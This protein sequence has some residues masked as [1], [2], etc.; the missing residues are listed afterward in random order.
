MSNSLSIVNA[1]VVVRLALTIWTAK[2]KLNRSDLPDTDNLPPEELASLGSKRLF[3][4]AKLRPF[5]AIKSRAVSF[6]DKQGVKFLGGW[7]I[8][9]KNVS[10]VSKELAN[11]HTEF[12]TAV[13]SFVADYTAGVQDWLA[14]YPQ[15]SNVL[16]NAMPS[17]TEIPRRFNFTWQMYKVEPV[18]THHTASD[19][20]DM[21]DSIRGVSDKALTEVQSMM[22]KVYSE[23]FAGK[24]EHINRK[25]LRTAENV[26][27]KLDKMSFTHPALSMIYS[28]LKDTIDIMRQPHV[29]DANQR[30]FHR[31][32]HR[33]CHTD[34]LKAILEHYDLGTINV[35]EMKN[36]IDDALYSAREDTENLMDMEDDTPFRT[37]DS[38]LEP[39]VQEPESGEKSLSDLLDML[40]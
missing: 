22:E 24:G 35:D 31:V 18:N 39:A 5:G 6:M 17:V 32:L 21:H 38:E 30:M 36:E 27:A 12:E 29:S 20:A 26:L 23:C 8:D 28:E 1:A 37:A 25:S 11:L 33:F 2:A 34:S 10:A 13:S 14:T 15:W 9:E 3:N 4:P 40:Y 19:G 16:A 7:L